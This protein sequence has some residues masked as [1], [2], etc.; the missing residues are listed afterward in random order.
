MG[1][2]VAYGATNVTINFLVSS[3]NQSIAHTCFTPP[4]IS[5]HFIGGAVGT[6][7]PLKGKSF[8]FSRKVTRI[9]Y[10]SYQMRTGDTA[11][12]YVNNNKQILNNSMLSVPLARCGFSFTPTSI[13]ASGDLKG[14]TMYA[15]TS[16]STGGLYVNH[17]IDFFP[18]QPMDSFTVFTNTSIPATIGCN[19]PFGGEVFFA[20]DTLAYINQ[21]LTIVPVCAGDTIKIPYKVSNTFNSGN[22][23]TAQLSNAAGSFATPVNIG[24]RTDTT[25]DTIRCIIPRTTTG[26]S[27]YRIRIV[28]SSPSS[29]SFDNGTNIQIKALA[30][31]RTI[32]NNSPVCEPDTVRLFSS[33]STAGTMYSWVGPLSFIANTAN[34]QTGNTTAAN[35][36]QYILTMTTSQGCIS[37]DTTTVTVKPLPQKPVANSDTSLCPNTTLH[38]SATTTTIGVNWAWT[39]PN[40]YNSTAQNPSR[41]GMTTADAGNYIVT[42]TLNGCSRKDTT[43]TTVFGITATPVPSANTPV[44]IGQDLNLTATNV[45]GATYAWTST[46]GYSSA[47]QNPIISTATTAMAGKYYVQATANGCASG[48]DS[49]TVTVNPAPMINMYPSPKDSICQGAMLTLISNQNNAGTVFQRKWYRNNTL[50]STATGASYST[51]TAADNDVYFVTLTGGNCAEPFTDTSNQIPI[52]VFPWLAPKVSIIANPT[53]TVPSGTTINFTATPTN[54][55]NSPT[56]QWTRNGSNIVGALSNVWGAPTLSNNDEIC[57][58]MTSSYLC[59]NPKTVKSNCIKVSIET[60]GIKGTWASKQPSIYP[61]PVKD[62]LIIEGIPTGTI[63]QLT[64]VAGRMLIRKTAISN[65][66]TVNTQSLIPGNYILLLDDNKGN[67][68]KMKITKE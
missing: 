12:F 31:N 9:R 46:T 10:V 60:T 3:A 61:N 17:Q 27:G 38:L 19:Y 45:A 37:K 49:V 66:E 53:T 11:S 39:G 41:T 22:I 35:S 63:I 28:S 13:T 7:P 54:G 2:P 40:S 25:S 62:L 34:A 16:S 47:L 57:V 23:F 58:N 42:A 50:I 52:R 36:G 8:V 21:P 14:D 6:I 4:Y 51:T 18:T 55:G 64:D 29:I 32:S 67:R 24:S 5:V 15:C 30:A 68:F 48:I 26:G 59:P 56:Y 20:S 33:T 44:C 43:N 65:N 1:G